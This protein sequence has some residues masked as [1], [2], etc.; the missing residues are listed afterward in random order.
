MQAKLFSSDRI[1]DVLSYVFD[2]SLCA[3]LNMQHFQAQKLVTVIGVPVVTVIGVPVVTTCPV[4][5]PC[6]LLPPW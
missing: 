1:C 4:T 6:Y 3:R 2:L 5:V